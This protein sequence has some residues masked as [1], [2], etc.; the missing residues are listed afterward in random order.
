MAYADR[1]TNANDKADVFFTGSTDG[2]TNWISPLRVSTDS[3]TNDQ[4]MPVL[5]V[6]PDGTQLFMAW[7][8]RRN[9]TNNSLID[10]YGRFGTTAANGSVSF[11]SEF[12]SS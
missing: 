2:G 8:D 12:V 1:G 9:D 5:T 6:E 11:G 7:Y 3:T 4:R 10:V